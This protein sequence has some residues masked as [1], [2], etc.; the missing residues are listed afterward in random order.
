MFRVSDWYTSLACFTFPTVFIGLRVDEIAALVDGDASGSRAAAVID[1]I[2]RTLPHIRG[3]A[4]IH[5]DACAPTDSASFQVAKGAIRSGDKGW[6]MLIESDKVKAAFKGGHTTRIC[7]H[8]YRRMDSI[9]EFRVFVKD[10]QIVAMSQ[11]RLDRHYG[12]LAGRRDEIWAKGRQF[13]EDAA[14]GLPA[15][16]IVVDV[17]L[18][19]A[20]EYMIVDMNNFGPPTDPLL[21]RSWDRDWDEEAGLKLLAKPTRLGGEVQV[22]F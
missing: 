15:D 17:Y 7:L 14:A 1:R 16:D 11:M 19:S 22:S 6:G 18:T 3:S 9:R 10:R 21:L 12:R 2:D 13:I 4:F 8:S 5:A 20:G